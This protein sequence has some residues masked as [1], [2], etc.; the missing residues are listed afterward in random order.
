MLDFTHPSSNAKFSS[1]F[2][3]LLFARLF[4]LGL[5]STGFTTLEV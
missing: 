3:L 4:K 1:F 5:N 2:A